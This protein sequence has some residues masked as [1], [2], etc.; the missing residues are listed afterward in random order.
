MTTVVLSA[1]GIFK[2]GFHLFFYFNKSQDV[3]GSLARLFWSQTFS[4]LRF[5]QVY[6]GHSEGG[7]M[8]RC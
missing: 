8:T 6:V 3:E 2:P 7:W 4:A 1:Q 5:P